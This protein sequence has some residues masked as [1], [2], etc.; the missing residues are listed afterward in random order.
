M[1]SAGKDE[2]A[3]AMTAAD[4]QVTNWTVTP[5]DMLS[6]ARQVAMAMVSL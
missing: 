1:R 6:F 2:L 4:G 5:S 3:Y